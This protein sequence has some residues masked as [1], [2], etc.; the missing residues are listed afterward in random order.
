MM[1][2]NKFFSNTLQ[3]ACLCILEENR[4]DDGRGTKQTQKKG[5]KKLYKEAEHGVG[6]QRSALAPSNIY[7]L[8][9]SA[10]FLNMALF[11]INRSLHAYI[12]KFT[13]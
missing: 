12:C 13:L 2:F 7:S 9:S 8:A 10:F 5:K 1:S 3:S 6:K 4:Q 11:S